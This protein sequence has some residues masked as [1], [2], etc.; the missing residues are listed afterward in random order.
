MLN[1]IHLL[2]P[3]QLPPDYQAVL[4]SAASASTSVKDSLDPVWDSVFDSA[5]YGSIVDIGTVLAV[6]SLGWF[7]TKLGTEWMEGGSDQVL[8]R[9]ISVFVAIALLANQ[10]ALMSDVTLGVRNAAITLT[11][12]VLQQA[13]DG[14]DLQTSYRDAR[15]QEA[16]QATY[17]SQ[18]Q[19]CLDAS[20][21]TPRRDERCRSLASI[22]RSNFLASQGSTASE[23]EDL[24]W[25]GS[26]IQAALSAILW[27]VHLAYTWLLEI[28]LLLIGLLGPLAVGLSLL[29]T[30][31]KVLF[32]WMGGFFA[33]LLSRLTFNI[34]SG[35]AAYMTIQADIG[36]IN[37]LVLPI[38][39]GL[40]AP[41]LAT[42]VGLQGGGALT[43]ALATA[44]TYKGY[45]GLGAL[46]SR[47]PGFLFR[48]G[49]SLTRHRR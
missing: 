20:Q 37:S 40:L 1:H 34:V 7:L 3:A 32:T 8:P 12:T 15:L 47:A 9:L 49:R 23:S 42:F 38:L 27:A 44:A 5:L 39:L 31:D 4:D 43:Q 41:I 19:A 25:I 36:A 30:P 26:A 48:R 13:I 21:G 11:D 46:T 10:G 18:Y 35:L 24:G 45:S 17:T 22:A 16:A 6:L 33:V 14:T 2:I 29:P 28:V